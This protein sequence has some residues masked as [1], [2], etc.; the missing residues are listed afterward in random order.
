[1]YNNTKKF[2]MKNT[3]LPIVVIIAAIAIVYGILYY[4]KASYHDVPVYS[5]YTNKKLQILEKT[6]ETYLVRN[7]YLNPTADEISKYAYISLTEAKK[8]VGA[9]TIPLIEGTM[10]SFSVWETIGMSFGI[11]AGIFMVLLILAPFT[12]AFGI[13]RSIVK[14]VIGHSPRWGT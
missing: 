14:L 3:I 2:N 1:M 12:M 8:V 10:K 11:I 7:E 4:T 13:S 6:K 9:E 5:Q